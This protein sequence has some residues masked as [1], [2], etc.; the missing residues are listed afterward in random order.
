[1]IEQRS[2]RTCRSILSPLTSMA[3]T[4]PKTCSRPKRTLPAIRWC[5]ALSKRSM[6]RSKPLP[7]PTCPLFWSEFNA[8]YDNN[9]DVTDSIYMGPFMA[10]TISQCDGMTDAMS[11]WTLSDVF[12]EQ[13]VLKQPF[14]GGF[15]LIAAGGIPKPAFYAFAIL[16]DLGDQ[17]IPNSSSDV[18]VTKA[19][20]GALLLAAWN[21]VNPGDTGSPKT[22][23]SSNSKA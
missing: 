6:T 23:C 16:H 5:V 8:A 22:R 14:Y 17:R 2:P 20:D 9:V 19:K 12:E 11:Y 13:G 3:T 10:N 7:V 21:L 18:L 4:P 1:M 15:G